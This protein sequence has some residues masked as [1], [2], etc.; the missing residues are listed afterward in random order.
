MGVASAIGGVMLDGTPKRVW[1]VAMLVSAA[2]VVGSLALGPWA[3]RR[4]PSGGPAGE[5]VVSR[6]TAEASPG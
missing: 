4:L 5:V 2:G 1:I 6:R 3:R